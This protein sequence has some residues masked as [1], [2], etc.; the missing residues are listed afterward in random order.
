MSWKRYFTP[1]EGEA[2]TRSPSSG[3]GT[4]PWPARSNYSVFYLMYTQALLIELS[5]MDNIM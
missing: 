5:D 1:V 2:G 4:Q 3:Q